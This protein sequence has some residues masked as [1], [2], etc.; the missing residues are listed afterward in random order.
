MNAYQYSPEI[1]IFDA[2][3]I[4][5]SPEG[6]TY[7]LCKSCKS[8][9]PVKIIPS[10]FNSDY[11]PLNYCPVCSNSIDDELELGLCIKG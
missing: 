6:K 1:A 9:I 10:Y 5:S 7:Y 8:C 4:I 2:F 11:I 3:S